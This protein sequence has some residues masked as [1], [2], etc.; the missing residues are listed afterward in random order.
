MIRH[1]ALPPKPEPAVP[2]RTWDPRN[3]P[4]C[5][6]LDRAFPL[7]QCV[8]IPVNAVYLSSGGH[9]YSVHDN[10]GPRAGWY[11]PDAAGAASLGP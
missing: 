8:P 9:A 3:E 1:S 6:V 5:D 2:A 11:V 7:D 10:G 4:T